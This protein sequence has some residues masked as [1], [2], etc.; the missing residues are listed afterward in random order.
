MIWFNDQS[1]LLKITQRAKDVERLSKVLENVKYAYAHMT[2]NRSNDNALYQ[3]ALLSI[4]VSSKH[5]ASQCFLSR[6]IGA[7][8]YSLR[9][10]IKC[11]HVDQTGENIWGGG[12]PQN[13]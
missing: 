7:S 1:N 9:K 3:H 4:V 13:Q 11:V 12:L 6:T 2:T 5:K 10:S 8:K